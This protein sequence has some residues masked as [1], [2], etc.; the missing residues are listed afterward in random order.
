MNAESF[1]K[2]TYLCKVFRGF[3]FS[4]NLIVCMWNDVK[5]VIFLF[6]LIVCIFCFF[7]RLNNTCFLTINEA[8]VENLDVYSYFSLL[9]S[10][11]GHGGSRAA[12]YVKNNLFKNLSNHPDFIKNTKS[13]IGLRF[14]HC[15]F[16]ILES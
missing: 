5:F 15:L 1:A 2:G 16:L 13:A 7:Y 8:N 11:L 6:I 14:M 3:F 10:D 12:E 9:I 4:L